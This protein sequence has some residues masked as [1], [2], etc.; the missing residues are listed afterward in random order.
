MLLVRV[1]LWKC[2]RIC[3]KLKM[4]AR[5]TTVLRTSG[6][7]IRQ[8]KTSFGTRTNIEIL[9]EKK[10]GNAPEMVRS[11]FCLDVVGPSVAIY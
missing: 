3:R 8:R 9:M 1:R 2:L 6:R 10:K 11:P 7:I 4:T 5:F